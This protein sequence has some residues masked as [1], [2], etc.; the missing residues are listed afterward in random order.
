[1]KIFKR[2][3]LKNMI[4]DLNEFFGYRDIMLF[5]LVQFVLTFNIYFSSIYRQK[6]GKRTLSFNFYE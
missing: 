1:M 4:V 5:M 3:L 6:I 2:L